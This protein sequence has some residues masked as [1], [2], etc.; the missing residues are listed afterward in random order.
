M[1]VLYGLAGA[2]TS[3][4]DASPGLISSFVGFA[5]V[6]IPLTLLHELGHAFVARR[7]VGGDVDVTV[8]TSGQFAELR[9]GR[10]AVALN[11]LSDPTRRAGVARFDASHATTRDIVAIALAGPAASFAGFV[12]SAWAYSAAGGGLLWCA[13]FASAGGTLINL[14]PMQLQERPGEP[15]VRTDGALALEALRTARGSRPVTPIAPRRGDEPLRG[16]RGAPLGVE[17]MSRA[18]RGDGDL[19]AQRAQRLAANRHRSTP[20][21]S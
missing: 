12:V 21:P 10:I 15:P 20:P 14:I 13:T 2:I 7:R 16:R 8:G 11:G 17:P 9:L 3:F 4:M 18:S 5:I 6:G 1:D 19:L